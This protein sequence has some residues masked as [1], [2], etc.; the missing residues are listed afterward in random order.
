MWAENLKT[1]REGTIQEREP[2]IGMHREME[3]RSAGKAP[4]WPG[5]TTT[6]TDAPAKHATTL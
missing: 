5:R 6:E 1:G 3:D 2:Y 4:P